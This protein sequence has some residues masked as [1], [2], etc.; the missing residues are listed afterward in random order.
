MSQQGSWFKLKGIRSSLIYVGYV[1]LLLDF[2]TPAF[3]QTS[4]YLQHRYKPDR[5]A[6]IWL[7][8][9]YKIQT[10]DTTFTKYHIVAFSDEDLLISSIELKDTVQL[11]FADIERIVK[12]RKFG[13][14]EAIGTLGLVCLISTPGLWAT[15]RSDEANLLKGLE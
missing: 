15:G 14:F 10:A 7:D 9:E 8:K 12:I 13:L 11:L 2:A 4:L 5:E 6:K 3:G 1:A